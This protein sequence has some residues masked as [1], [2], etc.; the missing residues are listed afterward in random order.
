MTKK[1][2]FSLGPRKTRMEPAHGK[3]SPTSTW[4]KI[5]LKVSSLSKVVFLVAWARQSMALFWRLPHH[6]GPPYRSLLRG[7]PHYQPRQACVFLN[8]DFSGQTLLKLVA[9][10]C[11][12]AIFKMCTHTQMHRYTYLCTFYSCIC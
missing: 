8:S 5:L 7:N 3:T 4:Q 10:S 12:C 11:I 1:V 2:K 9:S 6:C